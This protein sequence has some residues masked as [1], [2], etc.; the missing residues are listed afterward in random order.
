MNTAA[1]AA[2]RLG[3][4]RGFTMLGVDGGF[5]GLLEGQ[6]RNLT[7]ADVDHWTGT[8]GAE[9]GTRRTIPTIDQYYALGR[10]LEKNEIDAII[11]IGGFSGYQAVWEILKERGRYPA[12]NIPFICVPASIDNNLP[13][14]ELSIGADTA[15]NNITEVLDR[16]KQSA[17]ASRRCFVAETMGR[18]CGYLALMSGISSGAEQV[19][20]S[21][22]GI[23]LDSLT[24]E[25]RRMV[26]NFK[27][28]R[29][30]YLVVRNEEASRT[31]RRTSLRRS[32]PRRVLGYLTS[33]QQSLGICNREETLHRSIA[34]SRS[35]SHLRLLMS[36]PGSLPPASL[37]AP[38]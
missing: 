26:S 9:L 35:N 4:E 21:E 25:A 29:N 27:R 34:L 19:Y 31:T 1:R 38:T 14:S 20:L 30:L 2:V 16:I 10:V 23:T 8:G 33:A 5:P 18:R 3:E 17:S 24:E 11:M 15:L 6:I 22:T 12:F 7:W 32:L 36:C 37:A 13:G 28:G